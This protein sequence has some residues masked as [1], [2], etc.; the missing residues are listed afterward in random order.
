ML[1]TRKLSRSQAHSDFLKAAL[2]SAFK[3]PLI[4][5]RYAQGK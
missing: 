4:K 5:E 1:L 2:R 3:N